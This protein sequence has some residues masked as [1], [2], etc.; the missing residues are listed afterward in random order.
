M[1]QVTVPI[2]ARLSELVGPQRFVADPSALAPYEVDGLRP[3]SALRPGSAAEVADILRLAAAENLAVIPMAGRTKL[4]IGM[5]PQ[6]YDLAL[7]LSEMNRVLAYDPR[8]LTLSVEPGARFAAVER[9][10]AERGQFLPLAPAFAD[11][12]TLGGMVV[13]GADTPLRYGYGT[14]RDCLLGLELV[15]GE[16]I[17]SKSGGRV[18]KNVT[19]Y[20][21]HK[22]LIGSLGTLAVI[23]RL[24]FRTFPLPQER[25]MFVASF[26]EPQGALDL[27]AAIARSP[28]RPHLLDIVGPRAALLFVET[29]PARIPSAYWSVVIEAAGHRAVVERHAGDL[30]RL[31]RENRAAEFTALDE[32]QGAALFAAIREFP[33]LVT[34]HHP[35]AAIFR[36]PSLP[37]QMLSALQ[38][39]W[40]A[41]HSEELH[42][43]TV[44]RATGVVY[45]A[46]LPPESG[47]GGALLL[48][49]CRD[50]MESGR[51]AC[52]QPMIEWCPPEVKA[53]MNVWPAPGSE[54]ALAERLKNVFDPH[55]VLSPGRFQG[56]I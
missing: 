26:A 47:A 53:A 46:F 22:F 29:T 13:A 7:D 11:R 19:G 52:A 6:K 55:R 51:S 38:R 32:S 30:D 44:I 8:D 49:A 27:C 10:L 43:A 50:L 34:E 15:T 24:N 33:R 17:A 20:D 42:I 21:L 45:T 23:T 31:A 40:A 5:P 2:G 1:S 12:A 3:S 37:G 16:G 18:V 39:A 54:R 36:T 25:Q 41:A 9:Q 48:A 4:R 28:L 56:G 14:A 35:G